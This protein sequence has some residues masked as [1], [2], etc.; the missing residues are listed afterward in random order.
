[1]RS[2]CFLCLLAMI[3]TAAHAGLSDEPT[4]T[5]V[6]LARV[7]ITPETP[8]R[9]TGYGNRTTESEGVEQALWARAVAIGRDDQI[10]VVLVTL[11][12]CGVPAELVDRAKARI[13]S[14]VGLGPERVAVCVTHTHSGP[15][16]NGYAPMIFADDP[17]A[18]HQQHLDAYALMLERKIEQVVIE[19][20]NASAPARLS[21]GRGTAD[22][23]V[24]RRVVENGVYR[25]FGVSR[26]A[27][28]DHDLPVLKVTNP[29]G[30]LRGLVVGYACHC[31]TLDGSF[32]K[33]CG[34]WAGYAVERIEAEHPGAL[35][36]IVIGCGAD[37]NP[38]PRGRLDQARAHG[39]SVADAVRDVLARPMA[40]VPPLR[41]AT[42]TRIALDHQP[43]PSESHWKQ[44]AEKQGQPGRRARALLNILASGN[45]IP[46]TLRYTTQTWQFG[47]DLA[48]VFLA[49]EVVVDYATRL[50][51]E[52]PEVPLW[53]VAYA[54]DVPCYIPSKRILA[55]GGY[56]AVDS[57]IYYNRPSPL[58]DSTEDRIIATVKR[59]LRG[60]RN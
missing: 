52:I 51:A 3:G 19:A 34:D 35:A 33:I 57:M 38:E 14:R 54:N 17:P 9:L 16:V 53:L 13:E 49:G 27:P 11:D 56:E 31:T 59:M 20:W 4:Q 44:E 36:M 26:D 50:R 28:V 1:M 43:V 47:D 55:E 41:A 46:S 25:G 39:Q 32:N 45:P 7:D 18:E 2:G 8:I 12:L 42:L 30:A 58:A 37:A 5:L 24:N 6:G 15:A 48:F 10:P 23:A 21:W 22:F 29:E 60:E 40:A